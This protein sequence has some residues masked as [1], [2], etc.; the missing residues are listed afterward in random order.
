[1]SENINKELI[2]ALGGE[3]ALRAL[4]EKL[5]VSQ[6]VVERMNDERHALFD[7]HPDRWVAMGI[8]GIVTVSDSLDEVLSIV[9]SKGLGQTEVVIEF[10]D[11]KPQLRVQ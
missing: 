11:T 3:D 9:D 10:M 6:K 7:K 2:D 5:A 4:T 1:M 8:N